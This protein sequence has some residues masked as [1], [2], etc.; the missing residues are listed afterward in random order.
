[1]A[2]GDGR[3]GTKEEGRPGSHG[4]PPVWGLGFK[5]K[6]EKERQEKRGEEKG[7]LVVQEVRGQ[8]PRPGWPVE[9]PVIEL[10]RPRLDV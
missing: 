8:G 10:D 1:M 2:E 6:M 3:G 9:S 5:A 4:R 7:V